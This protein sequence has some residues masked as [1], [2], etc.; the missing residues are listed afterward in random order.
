[1]YL[2]VKN[3]NF[4]LVLQEYIKCAYIIFYNAFDRNSIVFKK[5]MKSFINVSPVN[6]KQRKLVWG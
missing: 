3:Q 2:E 5:K 1:M 4:F 6:S